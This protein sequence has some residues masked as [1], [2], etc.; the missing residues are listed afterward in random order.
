MSRM[1]Q[2]LAATSKQP[3]GNTTSESNPDMLRQALK[4]GRNPHVCI[5]G[6]GFAGLR[7]ADILLQQGVKV[8]IFEARHRIGGRVS[9]SSTKSTPSP[10]RAPALSSKSW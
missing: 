2:D 9:F 1:Q 7:C 6:A 8:T 10:D 4:N 5:V 3:R